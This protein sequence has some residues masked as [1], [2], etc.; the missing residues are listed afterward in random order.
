AAVV[1]T[2]RSDNP[3][4]LNNVRAVPGQFPGALD[5]RATTRN[6]NMTVA[7][8]RAIAELLPAE[9][10]RPDYVI[11]SPFDVRVA[12]AVAR[13]GG[14]AGGLGG[15][16]SGRGL[17]PRGGAAFSPPPGGPPRAHG[18]R[19]PLVE[20]RRDD[21]VRPEG[22]RRDELG[23]GAAAATFI[24]SLIVVARTSRAPRNR[25]GKARTLFTCSGSR[26]GRCRRPPRRRR[27]PLPA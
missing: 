24:F 9:A 5:V 26:T 17:C 15:R 13:G 6:E 1:G 18:R 14:R 3:N 22:F 7:A 27:G 21:V 4:H 11:P 2:G 12:P 19:D 16:V 25:P 20:R 10:L 23:D 8:A